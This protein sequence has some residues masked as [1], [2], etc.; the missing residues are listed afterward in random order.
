MN[1]L[2]FRYVSGPE[3]NYHSVYKVLPGEYWQFGHDKGI[4]PKKKII[5]NFQIHFP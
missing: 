4:R 3:T 2:L 5:I 1:N